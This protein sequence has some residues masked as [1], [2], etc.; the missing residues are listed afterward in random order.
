MARA[1][2]PDRRGIQLRPDDFRTYLRAK[3]ETIAPADV[4]QLAAHAGDLRARA[5]RHAAEHPLLAERLALALDLVADHMAER[6]PQIPY[7][8]VALLAAALYYF[9]APVDVI[10]DFLPGVGMSDDALVI[11]LAV[12]LGAAG[13]ERYLVW[14]GLDAAV[15]PA[16][17]IVRPTRRTR[18]RS[19]SRRR[20]RTRRRR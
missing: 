18:D 3:A 17:A 10:P 19:A 9:V 13:V 6:C 2:R 11:E 16:P 5:A 8:T 1:T 12:G 4:A 15:L 7:Y 14:K 20:G